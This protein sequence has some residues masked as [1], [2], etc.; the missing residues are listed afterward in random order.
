MNKPNPH[1]IMYAPAKGKAKQLWISEEYIMIKTSVGAEYLNKKRYS[2]QSWNHIEL[3][4]RR[5]YNY[6]SIPNVS[7]TYYKEK[8]PAA[9]ELI[10]LATTPPELKDI[11]YE[12]IADC[13][14]YEK[15][16]KLEKPNHRKQLAQAAALV[17]VSINYIKS[18]NYNLRSN[19]LFKQLSK[20][21]ADTNIKYLPANDRRLKEKILTAA[22]GK[23]IEEVVCLPRQGNANAATYISEQI[24]YWIVQLASN[25][26]NF[27]DA[28]I[29]RKVREL[30]VLN[31][32]KAPSEEWI[33]NRLADRELR[34]IA[35]ISKYGTGTRGASQ[36]EDYIPIAR[37]PFAGDCWQV[38]ATRINMIAHS[39]EVDKD[40]KKQRVMANAMVCAV[41]DVYSGN[42]LGYSFGYAESHTMYHAALRMAV[43]TAGYL[44]YELALD[45]HPGYNTEAMIFL[46]ETMQ[47]MGVK[48]TI[49]TKAT[50]KAALERWF[51]TMQQ[52]EMPDSDYYYGE[53]IRSKNNYAHR[54]P[55]YL[56]KMR[57]QAQKEGY[58]L[59]DTINEYAM[60]IDRHCKRAYS[61]YSR[62]YKHVESSPY[63]LHEQCEKPNVIEV[64]AQQIN[65]VFGLKTSVII[66]GTGLIKI[67]LNHVDFYYRCSYETAKKNERVV[68]S[69]DPFDMSQVC[70]YK[71]VKESRWLIHL[72][73][74]EEFLPPQVYGPGAELGKLSA[75]RAEI[76]EFNRRRAED[77]QEA[78]KEPCT[79]TEEEYDFDSE[80]VMLMGRHT[81]KK[82]AC[83]YDEEVEIS[84]R[85]SIFNQFYNH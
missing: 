67:R 2:C 17:D 80:E 10:E 43:E 45:K 20:F 79:V 9:E 84:P 81:M 44:P 82:A 59:A 18:A 83:G 13:S 29:A 7:P 69:Y 55:D 25:S 62:K 40:G 46:R 73:E 11:W 34:F 33:R 77:L 47:L 57:K 30:C 75:A 53:G 19:V 31:K 14:S 1:I 71:P 24:E 52:I 58:C 35:G 38:D 26:K 76:K 50:G 16:Y 85:Q 15:L 21:I 54:S 4:G 51:S 68:V 41:R 64:N 42:V 36:I 60:L 48:I 12:A 27:S 3:D 65:Q 28:Y 66:K 23:S 70:L 39:R 6:N 5:Y 61:D 49:T 37:A 72:E 56:E 63:D 74:V 78:L 8:L 32:Y 22:Q